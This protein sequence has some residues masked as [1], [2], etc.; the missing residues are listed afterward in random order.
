MA[1]IKLPKYKKKNKEIIIYVNETLFN[2]ISKR[3]REAKLS[4]SKLIRQWLMGTINE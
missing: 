4:K 3:A 1:N 2:L